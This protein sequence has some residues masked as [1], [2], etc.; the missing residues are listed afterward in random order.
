M[1]ASPLLADGCNGFWVP[2]QLLVPSY[3]EF[4]FA[5]K[6]RL[7]QNYSYHGIYISI[8]GWLTVRRYTIRFIYREYTVYV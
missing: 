7:R 8:N 5:Q 6:H 2:M 3:S 1:D 4:F